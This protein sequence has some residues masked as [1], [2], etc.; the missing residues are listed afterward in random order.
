MKYSEFEIAKENCWNI[1][2][3]G[4][5]TY[6]TQKKRSFLHSLLKGDG[7]LLLIEQGEEAAVL[8]RMRRKR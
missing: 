2:G 6:W 1:D 4:I 8:Q 5:H 3:N 7:Y